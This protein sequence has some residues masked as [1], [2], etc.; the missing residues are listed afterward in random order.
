MMAPLKIEG[1][2]AISGSAN[3]VYKDKYNTGQVIHF[4]T[5]RMRGK[6]DTS[7]IASGSVQDSSNFILS[8]MIGYKGVTELYSHHPDISFNG[9]VKPLHTITQYPSS[10]FRYNG[11]PDPKEVIIPA[12]EI[13]NQDRRTMYAA[14]SI[15]NDSTHIYPSLFNFKRSYADLELTSDTGIFFYDEK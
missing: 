4:K 1:R 15:A 2:Y 7:I 3:Y 14:I 10:W 13:L 12:T 8:P 11:Q 5:I 6:G 9:Y